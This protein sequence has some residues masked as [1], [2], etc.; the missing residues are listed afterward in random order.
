MSAGRPERPV[1]RA[2]SDRLLDAARGAAPADPAPTNPLAAQDT[3]PADPPAD[4]DPAPTS[5]AAARDT[6]SVDPLAR[7]L[8]AA[9][10]P[11]RPHELAGEDA[12]VAAFRAARAAP[13]LAPARAPRRR[14]VTVG[15]LAWVA[16]V[17]ATATAGVAFAAV[18]L[19]VPWDPTPPHGPPTSAPATGV[20]DGS[21]TGTGPRTDG[22][23]GSPTAPGPGSASPSRTL[24]QNGPLT[25]HCRAYLAKKPAQRAKALE[26]SG[27]QPLVVAAGGAGQVEAYCRQLL[28]DD[29]SGDEDD[30]DS[31]KDKDEDKDKADKENDKADK[32]KDKD[33]DKDEANGADGGNVAG[34]R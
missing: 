8:A 11:A 1:D 2:E 21:S 26:T 20:P 23:G 18:T 30:T 3:P 31:G 5:P 27:F 25:G 13:A 10:A 16:G 33:K 4:P 15:V 17:A 14:R 6:R 29:P 34:N 7:L 22:P 24:E 9:A 28:P 12:A 32:E 19:D